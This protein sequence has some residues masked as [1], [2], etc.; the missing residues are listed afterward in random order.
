LTDEEKARAERARRLRQAIEERAKGKRPGPPRTP[1]E[2]VEER[3]RK[4][5]EKSKKEREDGRDES[6]R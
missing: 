6:S 1:R 4:L 3:M 5:A 2:F